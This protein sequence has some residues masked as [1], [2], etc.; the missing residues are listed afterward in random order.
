MEDMDLMIAPSRREVTVDPSS[1][2]LPQA[3]VK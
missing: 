3:R 1:P 2:D